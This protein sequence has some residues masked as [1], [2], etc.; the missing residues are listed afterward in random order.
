[1]KRILFLYIL[2]EIIPTFLL[3]I[4][5]FM[6]IIVMTQF[7]QMS[8]FLLIHNVSIKH[9]LMILFNMMVSFLPMIL[10]TSLLFSV[11]LS[12]A[13]MSADSEV[14]AFGALGYSPMKLASPAIAFSAVIAVLS[15]QTLFVIGPVARFNFD[16]LIQD[17]GN[18]KIL[19][20]IES[21]TFSEDFFSLTLYVNE[22][23]RRDNT[24]KDL[25]IY[26][27]RNS[28][29]PRVIVAKE[30]EVVASSDPDHSQSA[31][32]L[33][34][35]GHMFTRGAALA[36]QI[37]FESYRLTLASPSQPQVNDR[38][39]N[40]YVYQELI[41]EMTN[42][43]LPLSLR[44]DLFIEFHKRIATAAACLIFGFL[45]AGLG[46]TVH[47]R[48]TSSSGFI[49]SVIS[50]ALYWLS[51]AGVTALLPQSSLPPAILLWLPN[52]IFIGGTIW[53]WR[54]KA[55]LV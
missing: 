28:K 26:D 47:R 50:I 30:G 7:M 1:M 20:A 46:S 24:L 3:G 55:R 44:R 15:A 54:R 38:D 27:N 14:V 23:N 53:I 22:V 52:I 13:R 11:L 19:S 16:R 51:Y 41:R 35:D 48:S 17:I 39:A 31:T 18:Q 32:I 10:P 37:R 33:L 43:E 34:K 49:L 8:E 5:V 12:Y 29:A 4:A 9:F 45:G 21:G 6:F 36:S 40:T 2:G 42:L 25:F